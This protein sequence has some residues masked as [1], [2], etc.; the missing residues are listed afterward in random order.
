MSLKKSFP[1]SQ[2]LCVKRICSTSSEFKCNCKTLQYQFIKS[3]Y[4]SYLIETEIKEIKLLDRKEWLISKS[5]TESWSVTTDSDI[6]N[7]TLPNVRQ[8][9]QTHWSIV[10]TNKALEKT[11][12]VEP[13]FPH[14][15]NKSLKQLIRE[16][17][18]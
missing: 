2:I 18:I 13:M 10:K 12:S 15:K 3:G 11:F 8:L 4:D 1:Y 17:T 9:I 5:N 7:R 6:Y 16:N 14:C